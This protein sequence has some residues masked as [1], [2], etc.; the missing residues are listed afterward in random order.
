MKNPDGDGAA[1]LDLILAEYV[2]I[3]GKIPVRDP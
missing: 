1:A 2:E 3:I